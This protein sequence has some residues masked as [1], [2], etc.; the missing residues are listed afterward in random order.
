[1][2]KLPDLIESQT[3]KSLTEA[4]AKTKGNVSRAAALLGVSRY[5]VHRMIRR[6]G[7][8]REGGVRYI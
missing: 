6:F 7:L 8:K 3:R 4:L 1:M 2:Q 5:T